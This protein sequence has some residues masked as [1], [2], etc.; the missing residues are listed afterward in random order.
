MQADIERYFMSQEQED[1]AKWQ[2]FENYRKQ[3]AKAAVL[4][5]KLMKWGE[6]LFQFGSLLKAN[7][8]AMLYGKDKFDGLP[9]KD[10][11]RAA[12][13][14]WKNTLGVIQSLKNSLKEAGLDL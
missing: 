5:A 3:L 10:E 1:A 4:S 9:S 6:D 14:E 8:D 12:H 2:M 7:P 11:M 13:Q